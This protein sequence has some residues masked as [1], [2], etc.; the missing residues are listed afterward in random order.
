MAIRKGIRPAGA[1]H[2]NSQSGCLLLI[3]C[4]LRLKT[5]CDVLDVTVA[6]VA[7]GRNRTRPGLTTSKVELQSDPPAKMLLACVVLDSC[8]RFLIGT[9]R[10][11]TSV[12]VTLQVCAFTLH[13]CSRISALETC[14]PASACRWLFERC[15]YA[16]QRG[17]SIRYCRWTLHDQSQ[18]DYREADYRK[19]HW[20]MLADPS[21]A[22][23]YIA[24]T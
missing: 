23:P 16:V 14:I 3:T 10:C 9:T 7:T 8:I 4:E 13:V 18:A 19:R 17:W 15:R 21:E 6:T 12:S 24:P 5:G 20:Y 22:S 11:I 2:S 1:G